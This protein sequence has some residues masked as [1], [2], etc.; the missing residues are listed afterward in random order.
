MYAYF[1]E[2]T[3]EL[4][5]VAL[6]VIVAFVVTALLIWLIRPLAL[7][8]GLVD[9][10]NHR[11]QH[12]GSVPLIGGIAMYLG[13]TFAVLTLNISLRDYRSFLAGAGL[14][15]IIGLL[16]DFHELTPKKKFTAQIV[17]VVLMISWGELIIWQLG[18]IIPGAD[19][20][21]QLGNWNW[22]FTLV[23]S[24]AIINAI[25]M[26]DG[27][28]GLAGGY[29]LI[30]FTAMLS[31]SIM[32]ASIFDTR[33][34]ILLIATLVAFLLFN[35]RMPWREIAWVFMGDAGSMFLGFAVIWFIISLTQADEKIMKPVTA[36][37]IVALPLFDMVGVSLRRLLKGKPVFKADRSHFHHIIQ[38]AGYSSNKTTF[39]LLVVASCVAVIG[40]VASEY[41]QVPDS[42]MFI[43]FLVLFFLYFMGMQYAWKVMKVI[44][45]KHGA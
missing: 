3:S 37:W 32:S 22:V 4:R 33:L 40:V 19:F 10:P 38:V 13:F 11:K 25:N 36:L 43:S 8:L 26:S 23:G 14:L 15:I 39:V 2:L 17:A 18:P 21:L 44:S 29:V 1:E 31:L 9:H 12:T 45:K 20:N 5:V 7:R 16:D 24:L 30:A 42:I 28:D 35:M 41:Y 34:I 6:S 27:L